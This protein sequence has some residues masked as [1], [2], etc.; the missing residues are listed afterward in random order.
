MR[1]VSPI[2]KLYFTRPSAHLGLK[3]NIICEKLNDFLSI[4]SEHYT[5]SLSEFKDR[6]SAYSV[7]QLK[8]IP[9]SKFISCV[10]NVS[11]NSDAG[12]PDS[13]S[14][15]AILKYDLLFKGDRLSRGDKNA[16]HRG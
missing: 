5:L 4:I 3:L 12:L 10:I 2:Y 6:E 11:G 15:L 8:D 13:L 7:T 1:T 9:A 14:L 16:L